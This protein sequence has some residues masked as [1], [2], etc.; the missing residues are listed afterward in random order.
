M[1]NQLLQANLKKDSE[2]IQRVQGMVEE[3]LAT[4]KQMEV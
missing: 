2:I 1:N 3:L 4:W